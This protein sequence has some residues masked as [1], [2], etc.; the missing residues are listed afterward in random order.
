MGVLISHCC[1]SLPGDFGFD[2]LRLGENPDALKWYIA[3]NTKALCPCY[4]V[5]RASSLPHPNLR[6]VCLI[7]KPWLQVPAG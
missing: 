7:W 1:C 2:P 3:A 6:M 5:M 4:A